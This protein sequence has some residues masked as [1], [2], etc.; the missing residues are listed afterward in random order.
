MTVEEFNDCVKEADRRM[1]E[2]NGHNYMTILKT[3][4]MNCGRSPKVK[5]RCGGWLN[6][7]M[8]RLGH[9]LQEKGVI[10]NGN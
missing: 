7:F 4:C 8:D 9:V 5:T 3:R 10:T 6:T 1:K 2:S